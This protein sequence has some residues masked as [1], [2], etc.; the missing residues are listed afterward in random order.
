[1]LVN[2]ALILVAVSV[3]AIDVWLVIQILTGPPW[4]PTRNDAIA[5]MIALAEIGP[6]VIAAD[7]GAGDGRIVIAFARAG[8]EA[9]GY[10][11]NPLLVWRGRR[12]IRDAGLADRAFLHWKDFWSADLSSYHA[13]AIYGIP[14]IMGRL[15]RKLRRE[16]PMGVRIVSNGFTFHD[17][18]YVS[19]QNGIHLFVTKPK[20]DGMLS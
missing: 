11:R 5:V 14:Y 15:E 2:I 4:I 19:S 12:L 1:M 20:E 7:L 8:A 3:I 17:L 18:P 10:E 9:H 6:G 13:I 16:S